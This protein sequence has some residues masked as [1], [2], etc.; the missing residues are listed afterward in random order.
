MTKS[1]IESVLK[2]VPDLSG[3]GIGIFE[4]GRGLSWNE[5][6]LEFKKEQENLL[7]STEC[8]EKI[9]QGRTGVRPR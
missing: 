4:K 3:F 8:F 6:E 1:K 9:C 5:Y 2:R 7:D